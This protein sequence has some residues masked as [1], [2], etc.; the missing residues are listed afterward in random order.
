MTTTLTPEQ[1]ATLIERYADGHRVVSAAL[2]DIT[3]EELD[4]S[5]PGEWS[6]RQVVHHLADSETF[7]YGRI[8]TL[9]AEDNATIHAYDEGEFARRLNYD[10]PIEL[11]LTVLGAVR[12]STVEL[13]RLMTEDQWSRSGTHSE[14]GAYS[15]ERWLEIYAEHA[16]DHAEQIVRARR[17]EK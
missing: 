9:L 2:A 13:L 11:S 7:S 8:R 16:H 17:G 1:R 5:Y 3:A 14:S 4:R 6:A 10:R 15:V 12:A